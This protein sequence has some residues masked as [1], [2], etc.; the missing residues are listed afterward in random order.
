V[1]INGA[2][3]REA[4]SDNIELD[5]NHAHHIEVVVDRLVDQRAELVTR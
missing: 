4:S 2:E 1:R 5:K 3:V